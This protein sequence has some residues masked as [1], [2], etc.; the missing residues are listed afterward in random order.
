MARTP[1]LATDAMREKVRSRAAKGHRQEDIATFI[2]CDAK[3]LRK[4]FRRELDL[5]MAEANGE[6]A[7][8][9]FASAKAGN[10]AAQIF[11]AKTRL[12]WREC[13]AAD[14]PVSGTDAKSTSPVIILPDNGRD[15]GLTEVL[16]NAQDKYF[17]SKRHR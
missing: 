3:T 1:F 12:N 2:G 17:A 8:S 15:L 16:R 13:G 9:L 4:H 6:I 7:E 14:H 10:V 5:G 11:L